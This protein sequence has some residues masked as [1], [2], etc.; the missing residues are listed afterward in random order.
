MIHK[1][2]L[3]SAFLYSPLWNNRMGRIT[4]NSRSKHTKSETKFINRQQFLS[5]F[6]YDRQFWNPCCCRR[7]I[8]LFSTHWTKNL[9]LNRFS[10]FKPLISLEVSKKPDNDFLKSIKYF[11]FYFL[12]D[13]NKL[14]EPIDSNIS[15]TSKKTHYL[16][17]EFLY[18][19]FEIIIGAI[20]DIKGSGSYYTP[21]E[22]TEY[23]CSTSIDYLLSDFINSQSNGAIPCI[24][25][26]NNYSEI[27]EEN[28]KDYYTQLI[29]RLSTLRIADISC[30][31]GA[32]LLSA[33]DNVYTKICNLH[34]RFG[35]LNELNKFDLTKKVKDCLWCWDQW[36]H[37]FGIILLNLRVLNPG[38]SNQAN[39][40]NQANQNNS[41]YSLI[42]TN[43]QDP[44]IF[45]IEIVGSGNSFRDLGGS[46]EIQSPNW[47]IELDT[48]KNSNAQKLN[49]LLYKI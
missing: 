5:I 40:A 32:F 14:H 2:F 38:F 45:P 12:Q 33:A 39:Q 4:I 43:I 34:E 36:G 49:N 27:P 24:S 16:S 47:F 37:V 11:K 7:K 23:I 25:F 18:D 20:I 31:S 1:Y 9:L 6:W 46:E 19:I 35:V 10:F 21:K 13:L 8:V 48:N 3:R 15:D 28:L 17:I 30:G 26:L 22:I 29:S 44:T 42:L 41:I